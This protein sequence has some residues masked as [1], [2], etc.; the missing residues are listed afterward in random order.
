MEEAREAK[1]WVEEQRKRE[2]EE[3][4]ATKAFT[5][6]EAEVLR[7]QLDEA[8]RKKELRTDLRSMHRV[9]VQVSNQTGDIAD[10]VED[11]AK[12]FVPYQKE[13]VENSGNAREME[14]NEEETLQ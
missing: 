6:K 13:E 10:S 1:K 12:Y 9:A 8:K 2:E 5:Q 4:R 3:A 11:L 14:D 7:K